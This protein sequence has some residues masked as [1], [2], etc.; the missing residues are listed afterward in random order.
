MYA[1]DRS[2]I[3]GERHLAPGASR[4]YSLPWLGS[5][6][7]RPPIGAD[8]R[9]PLLIGPLRLR[10]S[11]RFALGG[12]HGM[13]PPTTQR[14]RARPAAASS[15][16]DSGPLLSWS[17]TTS[18]PSARLAVAGE[19]TPVTADR[20]HEAL[21]WLR[22][23]G[24]GQITVDLGGVSACTTAGLDALISVLH[25]VVATSAGSL[26]LTNPSRAVRRLLGLGDNTV[27]EDQ[28]AQA[29]HEGQVAS[30]PSEPA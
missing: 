28:A 3:H 11:D 29:P 25:R 15:H 13:A 19:L 4:T 20:L 14:T 9:S 6:P 30:F 5:Q 7:H 16:L 17:V 12:D 18:G 10:V 27:M 23:A 24:H 1:T 21:D 22:L 2:V 8:T 26:V